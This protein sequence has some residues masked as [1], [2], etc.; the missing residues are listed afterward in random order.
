MSPRNRLEETSLAEKGQKDY[1]S[2]GKKT[3]SDLALWREVQKTVS[4]LAMD[5]RVSFGLPF[6]ESSGEEESFDQP[7]VP[8]EKILTRSVQKKRTP[9][10]RRCG[11]ATPPALKNYLKEGDLKAMDR[12]QADRFKKGKVAIEAVLDLH[13]LTQAQAYEALNRY[14]CDCYNRGLRCVLLITGKGSAPGSEGIL[15]SMLPRWLN[16][17]PNRSRVL[18]FTTARRHHGGT[19]ALYLLIKR[20]RDSKEERKSPHVAQQKFLDT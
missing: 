7:E 2:K 11:G 9:L 13:G 14:V 1:K 19:G 3:L 17:T 15:K 20:R 16:E 18:A 12:R 4:P 8:R 5:Q 6:A 10:K